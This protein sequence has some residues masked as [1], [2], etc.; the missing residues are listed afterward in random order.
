MQRGEIDAIFDEGASRNQS[1]EYLS[2]RRNARKGRRKR[3]KFISHNV[4][5]ALRTWRLCALATAI[6]Q[7]RVFSAFRSSA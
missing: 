5:F 2:P 4:I 3:M 6:F 7:F 1:P